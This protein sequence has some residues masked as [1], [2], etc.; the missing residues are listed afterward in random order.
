MITL[1]K[2]V[3]TC[4]GCPSSWEGWDSEGTYYYFR[5]RWGYL[6]VD[7]TQEGKEPQALWGKQISDGLDGILNYYDM[8]NHLAELFEFPE[9]SELS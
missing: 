9:H 3:Q 7:Q 5:F 6:G 2:I 1:T 4:F 8:K